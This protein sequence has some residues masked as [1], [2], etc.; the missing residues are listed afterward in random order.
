MKRPN[1]KI[2]G[3]EE[4][5]KFQFKVTE[6]IFN[7]LIEE[8]FSKLK[9]KMPTKAQEVYRKPNGLDQRK[10]VLLPHYKQNTKHRKQRMNI[11]S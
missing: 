2:L 6:Y 1:V 9:K 8:I 10:N 11:K 4:R 5:E 7:K 3:R